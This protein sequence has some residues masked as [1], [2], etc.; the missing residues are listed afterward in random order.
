MKIIIVGPAHPYRGGIADTNESFAIALQN[1]GHQ[2]SIITFSVQYPSL[3]FPGKSQF[4]Q[5]VAPKDLK[6]SRLINTMNPLN[7]AKTAIAINKQQADLVIFRYWTPFLAIPLGYISRKIKNTKKIALCDNVIPHE[8]KFFDKA[9]TAYFLKPFD[10]FITLSNQVKEE[11]EQFSNA[12]IMVHPHPI[13]LNLGVAIPKHLA[14]EHLKLDIN[15][16]Y[17]LFFGLVRKYKGLDLM[18]KAMAERPIR[19]MNIKLLVV[20]EFYENPDTYKKLID[21]LKI[22]DSVEIR[23]QFVPTEEIKIYFSACDLVTQT[24]LTASQSGITQMALNFDKAVLVTD[25]GGL[26]E[27]IHHEKSGY[28][29]DKTPIAIADSIV[30]FY[31]NKREALFSKQAAEEKKKYSWESLSKEVIEFVEQLSISQ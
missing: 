24:Y 5:D 14:K 13:N 18:L 3:F 26:S 21:D 4:S 19:E 25:V 8:K 12:P 28:V 7:W 27:I 17:L 11:L 23:N 15:T 1:E 29:V 30:D 31:T 22:N 10:G 2:A 9:F 20:G 6:I 16:S